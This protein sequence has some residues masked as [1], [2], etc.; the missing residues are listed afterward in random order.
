MY[1][2][3]SSRGFVYTKLYEARKQTGYPWLFD[4]NF[5]GKSYLFDGRTGETFDQPVTIGQAYMLKLVHLVDDKIHARST[6]PYSLVTQQPLGGRA[7]HG[8]Q[9][10]GEM[11]VWALEGFGAAYTLQELLTVKSDDMK[12]RN[13]ALNSIIKG[14]PIP[15]P[16]TPESFKVLIRELQSLCLDIGVYKVHKSKQ[17]H[18]VDLMKA[19]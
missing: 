11:E 9:R 17:G 14:R 13:E 16:G 4:K 8:G 18:E 2:K 1:G 12:G 3:E 5:P 7:K 15:K 19:L 6:G 10:L